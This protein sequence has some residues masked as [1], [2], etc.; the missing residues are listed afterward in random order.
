[1]IK[2]HKAKHCGTQ[3]FNL[4]DPTSK[5]QR[6]CMDFVQATKPISWSM[7]MTSCSQEKSKKSTESSHRS[8][9]NMKEPGSTVS[10]FGKSQAEAVI[11]RSHKETVTLT[12]PYWKH[13]IPVQNEEL[14]NV[15]QHKQY[16]R[17]GLDSEHAINELATGPVAPR[18]QVSKKMKK[19]PPRP[20]QARRRRQRQ[21]PHYSQK[22]PCCLK[23]QTI[24]NPLRNNTKPEL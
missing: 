7:W 5:T 9:K 23:S 3:I 20:A 18:I 4:Q 8:R 13:E 17:R 12:T 1:M 21:K 2:H 14:L 16:R 24:T 19:A 11:T 22:P 15:E 6:Q 10:F